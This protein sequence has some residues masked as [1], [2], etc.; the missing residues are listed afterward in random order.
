MNIITATEILNVRHDAEY[1]VVR[2]VFLASHVQAPDQNRMDS[3][4]VAHNY[5]MAH[6]KDARVAEYK[7]LKPQSPKSLSVTPVV[8]RCP[9][10]ASTNVLKPALTYQLRFFLWKRRQIWP[11]RW[12]IVVLTFLVVMSG[13]LMAVAALFYLNY[14]AV[15]ALVDWSI[16]VGAWFGFM[17]IVLMLLFS[18][19]ILKLDWML[20]GS[21]MIGGWKC[22]TESLELDWQP[23][24]SSPTKTT[25]YI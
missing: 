16:S 22:V 12:L 3:L 21:M 7:A 24:E 1:L 25:R 8:A 13:R 11:V 2:S 10:P 18:L 17:V 15:V 6:D 4:A 20:A 5:F 23:G 14:L 19:A 9:D